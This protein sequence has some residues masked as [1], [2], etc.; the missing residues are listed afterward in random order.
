MIFIQNKMLI[1]N[2]DRV[3][4]ISGPKRGL[5]GQIVSLNAKKSFFIIKSNFNFNLFKIKLSNK[6]VLFETSNIYSEK[7]FLHNYN[8][9]KVFT[10]KNSKYAKKKI[11]LLNYVLAIKQK[12]IRIKSELKNYFVS[13]YSNVLLLKKKINLLT[14][15]KYKNASQNKFLFLK[16]LNLIAQKWQV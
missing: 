1:K 3:K 12:K 6:L 11:Q 9:V 5:I 16:K 8:K 15:L 4:V 2:G 14:N 7:N 10:I 13:G